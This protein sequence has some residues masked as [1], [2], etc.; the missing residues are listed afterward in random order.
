M[1]NE[2]QK[3]PIKSEIR[4]ELLQA[5]PSLATAI[6]EL[7]QPDANVKDVIEILELVRT[8]FSTLLDHPDLRK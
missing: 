4:H 1:T 3:L 2:P 6:D 7:K 8:K 5:V